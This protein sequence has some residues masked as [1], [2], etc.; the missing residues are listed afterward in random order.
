M[1]G[2]LNHLEARS[3]TFC[4][5]KKQGFLDDKSD[6]R[7][8][9]FCIIILSFFCFL[10]RAFSKDQNAWENDCYEVVKDPNQSANCNADSKELA[11]TKRLYDQLKQNAGM[12]S[13]LEKDFFWKF[14]I[15]QKKQTLC[16]QDLLKNLDLTPN[17]PKLCTKP[18]LL[19]ASSEDVRKRSDREKCQANP[20]LETATLHCHAQYETSADAKKIQ[21][22]VLASIWNHRK[23][24][25]ATRAACSEATLQ[26]VNTENAK[27]SSVAYTDKLTSIDVLEKNVSDRCTQ[28]A[29]VFSNIW[30]SDSS[31]MQDFLNRWLDE[32]AA[33]P[34]MEPSEF[35]ER[36]LKSQADAHTEKDPFVLQN[37]IV[38][39]SCAAEARDQALKQAVVATGERDQ[40]GDAVYKVI[41]GANVND[42]YR[43]LFLADGGTA[44][45]A[46]I[47]R[48]PE[49]QALAGPLSCHLVK[50]YYATPKKI[51]VVKAI[52]IGGVT[53]VLTLG[54]G[55]EISGALVA[56]VVLD[57][58]LAINSG[59]HAYET[60]KNSGFDPRSLES[61]PVCQ[62][63]KDNPKG[64]MLSS[65]MGNQE[66]CRGAS[67]G[68]A[69]SIVS[70]AVGGAGV[71]KALEAQEAAR[72]I[73]IVDDTKNLKTD[74]KVARNVAMTFH[75]TADGSSISES[76]RASR[77]TSAIALIHAHP[78][79]EQQ[80]AKELGKAELPKSVDAIA[81]NPEVKKALQAIAEHCRIDSLPIFGPRVSEPCE[82]SQLRR[83]VEAL[84]K[85]LARFGNL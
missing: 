76:T 80:V 83:D 55:A 27:Q 56:G 59:Y 21:F 32:F 23:E 10:P 36:A 72:A 57:A 44:A 53:T 81:E 2:F 66:T 84:R 29:K 79:V 11:N 19:A 43:K 68:A 5:I 41:N 12:R 82:P 6:V 60:C 22:D 46:Y 15:D 51:E 62:L 52:A 74:A 42:D 17:Y 38:K 48:N 69:V 20:N 63:M 1:H 45:L 14:L 70:T 47:N 30:S 61:A 7:P 18:S 77:N 71:K 25:I 49:F 13:D 16:E 9:V 85:V 28:K 39:M 75:N 31:E 26:L 8:S 67:L 35:K 40:N 24:L 58:A 3:S 73:K 65:R 4:L 64:A 50:T 34:N 33:H 78:N 54:A 37:T